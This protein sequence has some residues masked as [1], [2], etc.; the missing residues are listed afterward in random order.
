M[1]ASSIQRLLSPGAYPHQTTRHELVETHISWVILTGDLAYKIKKPVN[2]GFVDFSTLALREHFCHREVELN[3]RYTPEIYL[4]VVPVTGSLKD[5]RI[6]GE[7]PVIDY[8]VKMVQFDLD[9]LLDTVS[10]KGQLDTGLVRAMAAELARTHREFPSLTG[11]TDNPQAMGAAMIQN[12][13]QVREYHLDPAEVALLDVLEAWTREHIERLFPVMI[14][15]V[16]DGFVKDL[17]GDLHLNNMIVKDGKVKFFDCIEFRDD[18]RLMDTIAEIA[19]LAMDLARREQPAQQ[20]LNDYLEYSGDFDGLR[21]LDFYRVYFA[22]VRAK[23]SLIREP[24]SRENL[25]ASAAYASFRQFLLLARSFTEPK[26]PFI[27]MMH[28]VAGTGKST[29]AA[30]VAA[31]FG[32]LRL[33]SDVERKRLFGLSPDDS[34]DALEENIYTPR[35]T[36]DTYQH[37]QDLCRGI[38]MEGFPCIVDATFLQRSVRDVFLAMGEDLDVPVLI[39]DCRASAACIAE[40]LQLREQQQDDASE[41]GVDVMQLQLTQ[42]EPFT[43]REAQSVLA[44][45]TEQAFDASLILRRI[46]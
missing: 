10:N 1:D 20:V 38:V 24:V 42:S 36:R 16:Q 34:S 7:G 21:L 37:L 32:A 12:F 29:V 27:A 28:G 9:C 2:F 41:A 19:F 25:R 14:K 8:A 15:R 22:M 40:R 17:H 4:G 11:A 26:A 13:D 31:Q 6:D 23:V 39:L 33:R 35:A 30:R 43:P 18:F 5:P 3:R 45:D 46:H 44:I